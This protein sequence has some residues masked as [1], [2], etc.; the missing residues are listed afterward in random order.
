MPSH[1][2]MTRKYS[3]DCHVIGLNFSLFICLLQVTK[4]SH[5]VMYVNRIADDWHNTEHNK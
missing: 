5:T 2:V 4:C 3:K 1:T